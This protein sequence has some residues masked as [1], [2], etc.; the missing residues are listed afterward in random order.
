MCV[1]F[2]F[3]ILFYKLNEFNQLDWNGMA[4]EESRD[5]KPFPGIYLEYSNCSH[6]I[7]LRTQKK[8]SLCL[9]RWRELIH[10]IFPRSQ[11]IMV[12]TELE[13]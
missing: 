11:G 8:Q 3:F 6:S 13:L 5:P 10:L 2:N 1:N 7:I 4:T 12:M 9:H